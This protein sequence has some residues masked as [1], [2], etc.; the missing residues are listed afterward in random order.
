M[1]TTLQTMQRRVAEEVD[2]GEIDYR[3]VTIAL[4]EVTD[5]TS[6]A[7]AAERSGADGETWRWVG[8]SESEV[9]LVVG[10]GFERFYETNA[11]GTID[12]DPGFVLVDGN[13]VIRGEYRYQTLADDADKFIRHTQ[14]LAE[15]I[16]YGQGPASVAY[17]AAHLFLCY[18]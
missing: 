15:E 1:F 11:D 10:A 9:K 7:R 2:L 16:R 4:D 12:F 18:P 17:E 3:L 5:A 8:G 6:L 13:G 14:I